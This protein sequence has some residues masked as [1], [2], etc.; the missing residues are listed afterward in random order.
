[1]TGKS[2]CGA[3]D[4]ETRAKAQKAGGEA[5][6]ER[7]KAHFFTR[8]QADATIHLQR[9]ADVPSTIEVVARAVACG[10]L[11]T[12]VGN[13]LVVAANAAIGAIDSVER[14]AKNRAATMTDE[15]LDLAIEEEVAERMR[16]RR[17]PDEATQ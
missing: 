16:R 15:E 9:R 17:E 4:P 2:L 7:A 13:A 6:A 10:E 14:F 12:R 1:V 8:S 11:D 5:L 3:H